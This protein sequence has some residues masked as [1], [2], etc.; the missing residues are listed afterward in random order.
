MTCLTSLF[1]RSLCGAVWCLMLLLQRIP[2]GKFNVNIFLDDDKL[3][4]LHDPLDYS[5]LPDLKEKVNSYHRK[6]CWKIVQSFLFLGHR[7]GAVGLQ[8]VVTM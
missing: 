8:F 4:L 5:M 6:T 3:G 2:N 1:S 7:L